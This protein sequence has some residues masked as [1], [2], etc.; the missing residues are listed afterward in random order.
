MSPSPSFFSFCSQRQ[1]RAKRRRKGG[2]PKGKVLPIPP[3]LSKGDPSCLFHHIQGPW[4]LRMSTARY[5]FSQKPEFS[6]E[7]LVGGQSEPE[8][9]LRFPALLIAG[10]EPV[11]DLGNGCFPTGGHVRCQE[12]ELLCPDFVKVLW[13]PGWSDPSL[14]QH[15]SLGFT[16]WFWASHEIKCMWK[17]SG[18]KLLIYIEWLTLKKY[19][20]VSCDLCVVELFCYWPIYPPMVSDK[21]MSL[22]W[23]RSKRSYSVIKALK[24]RFVMK[25][26]DDLQFWSFTL[27]IISLLWSLLS[28]SYWK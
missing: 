21:I 26:A 20:D 8:T 17:L 19:P 24:D 5:S 16:W 25:K 10:H 15:W 6:E 7:R 18:I 11:M 12:S 1:G 22:L 2:T 27:V 14:R 28:L 4:S 23:N 3:E 9:L 13:L